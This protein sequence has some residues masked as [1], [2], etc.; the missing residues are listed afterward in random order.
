[1]PGSEFAIDARVSTG[2]EL[3]AGWYADQSIALATRFLDEFETAVQRLRAFPQSGSPHR[4]ETR[5]MRARGFP[6]LVVYRRASGVF[7]SL[8]SHAHGGAISGK[9]GSDGQLR[10]T[11]G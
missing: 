11:I 5:A 8:L 4:H 7:R 10:W 3:A 2:L 9:T 1:M 6:F